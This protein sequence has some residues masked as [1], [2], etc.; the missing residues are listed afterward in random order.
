MVSLGSKN[1]YIIGVDV[2]STTV[3]AVAVESASNKIIWEDYKRH[4][5]KLAEK[6]FDFLGRME[7]EIGIS[8]EETR[9]FFTGSGGSNLA[10]LVGGRFVQEVN[11]VSLAVEQLFPEVY[12]VIEL[13]GQDSKIV[14]FK[15]QP[16]GNSRK[17]IAT[18]NDKCAGGTGAVLDK[19]S[20][21]LNI[22][23]HQLSQQR[24]DGL[25]IH[26]VAGKC[27]VFSETDI[28]SL[29]KQG[30]PSDELMASLFEAI[31]LQ[32]LSVL[33]RGHTLYPQILLLGGPNT[34]IPGLQEAWRAQLP[35]LWEEREVTLP[36]GSELDKLI[37]APQNGHYFGSLGAIQFGR[38]QDPDVGRYTGLQHLE[39]YL[40]EGHSAKKARFAIKA[41]KSSEDDLAAFLEEYAPEPFTPPTVITD[42]PIP[43]FLGVDGGSTSTKAVLISEDG[44]VL[45]KAYRLS[46]GNPIQ[47]TIDLT[48]E[49]REQ[50]QSRGAS[51]E[52]IGAATTGYAKDV[53]QKVLRA[54]V[55]LVETVAHARSAIHFYGEPDVIVDVGGQDIKLIILKDGH[56]KD[57]MLNTQCSAGNGYFLQA[58]AESFGLEVSQYADKAF[59]AD[60]MPEFS[61]GCAVFLQ[62][63]IVN[64]QRQGWTPEELLAGLAA[65]LPKNIWLYVAKIP[66]LASLGRR[67]ILQGGTQRNLAAVK[68]QVDYI[69]NRFKRASIEPEITVHKHCGEAGAIGA[70][71]EARRLWLEGKKTDF[72]GLDAVGTIR[73]RTTSNE[74]TRCNFCKNGC[75]RTFIDY[76][77]EGVSQ[78]SQQH[79]ESRVPLMAG[80]NRL[81]VSTCEKG[82]VEDVDALR[83]ILAG[84]KEKKKSNPNLVDVAGRRIWKSFHPAPVADLLPKRTI[85]PAARRRAE[86]MK[87]RDQVR[88]GVPRVL[89][90]YLYAP[91]FSAYLESLGVESRNIV[92][93]DFTSDP[94]YREG[95][96]RGAIDPCFPAKVVIAHIHNL[97]YKHHKKKSLD[98]I[99][100]PM[101]DVLNTPLVNTLGTNACATVIATPQSA[102]AA[103]TKETDVFAQH[104]IS[105]LYPF[106]DLADRR[107]LERQMMQTWGD[108]LGLSTGENERAIKEGFAALDR[109]NTDIRKEAREIIDTLEKEQRIGVVMLGRS[110]HHDPGLN[111]GIFDEFQKRGYPILSQNNLPLDEDLL[112]RLFGQDVR[113]GVIQHPL[114]VTDV[115]KHP[116]IASTSLKIWAAKFTAR[117]PNLVGVEVSNFKCGHDAPLYQ[118][119]EQI[120]EGAGRPYF[121]FKDLDENKPTG[122]F[123]VRI[124]TIDYFL[125]RHREELIRREQ[126]MTNIG[127]QL[128]E[129]EAV[130]QSGMG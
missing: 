102:K 34:F 8:D 55:A 67:F 74:A 48:L 121:S 35:K 107:L 5:T 114:D 45:C 81:I 12:S 87:S 11:A 20:A 126:L 106:I 21:K 17:K 38:E 123:R 19:I 111:H 23:Q 75:L 33:T 40:V 6:V 76:S 42:R 86:L 93:S 119:I 52:I 56:V 90:M 92:Y 79:T 100:L 101:F 59:G 64:Y 25:R 116:Y 18:M 24:Y 57:F 77:A 69:R 130:L 39:H 112:D 22:E 71:L 60:V 10:G 117:H 78:G 54:D 51:T 13:G 109:W 103:F 125:K 31:V 104:G 47:D 7:T 50:I 53:L 91:F 49:L 97:I 118:V 27:G 88:I 89:G 29:Q 127:R 108:I 41:L 99:F 129:Y 73:Y 72:I 124:E 83:V 9:I 66:N 43:A 105:Y 85:M 61:Y 128:R 37:R 68:A 4:E 30:I 26:R 95:T 16:G 94:M 3:K 82:S 58:T 115:W 15:D 28:N 96:R 113:D 63:D 2:G 122:S 46:R 44:D 70:G 32:N 14:L 110:Y 1:D 120:I 84:L 65:V 62:A 80:E 98:H 36:A